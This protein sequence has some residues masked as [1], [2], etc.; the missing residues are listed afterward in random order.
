MKYVFKTL[1]VISIGSGLA[2]TTSIVSDIQF[3]L[4]AVFIIGGLNLL[5]D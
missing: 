4:V 1:G 3:T 5:K 2:L